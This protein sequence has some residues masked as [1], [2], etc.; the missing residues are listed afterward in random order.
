MALAALLLAGCVVQ[1]QR[2]MPRIAAERA[3][4][5]VAQDE[6]LDVGV[7]LFDPNVPESEQEREKHEQY[8]RD[9]QLPF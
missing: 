5:E 3:T 9:N 4:T 1:D 2:P 6:L 8:V 7:R